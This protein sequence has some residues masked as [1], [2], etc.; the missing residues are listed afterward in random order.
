[1][2]EIKYRGY[3]DFEGNVLYPPDRRWVYGYYYFQ[4]GVDWIKDIEDWR[5]SYVVCKGSVGEYI[6]L[7][8]ESGRE[9]YDG[10]VVSAI[11]WSGRE[12]DDWVKEEV[13]AR[14]CWRQELL[15]F[16]FIEDTRCK[17]QI[18]ALGRLEEHSLKVIDNT[19]ER[20]NRVDFGKSQE[21]QERNEEGHASNYACRLN[22]PCS[23][24]QAVE[25][26]G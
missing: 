12:F 14:V 7:K 2:R 11:Y 17:P 23:E 22:C 9:V 1:M 18:F 10:D 26:G 8:D 3:R 24:C 16:I 6:G 21:L 15:S 20:Q 4:D 25:K 19:Y 13:V 5:M